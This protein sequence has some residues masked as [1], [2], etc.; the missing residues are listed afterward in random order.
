MTDNVVD[1][2]E[3]QQKLIQWDLNQMSLDDLKEYFV[4]MQKLCNCRCWFICNEIVP[5]SLPVSTVDLC[6]KR[7]NINSSVKTKNLVSFMVALGYKDSVK[8]L[9][10][11]V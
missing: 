11:A 10:Y 2:D 5:H 3:L 7:R 9:N 8:P 1:R 4:N 6:T